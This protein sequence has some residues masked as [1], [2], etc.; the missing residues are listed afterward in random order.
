MNKILKFSL[1]NTI[2]I[3][4]LAILVIVGGIYSTNNIKVESFPNLVMPT[5]FVQATYG[6]H[7]TQELEDQL[8]N[9]IEDSIKQQK[10]YDT[11]TSTSRNNS[12][13][14]TVSYPFHTDIDKQKSTLEEAINKV[15]IPDGAKVEV[16]KLDNAAQPVYEVAFAGSGNQDIQSSLENDLVPKL[17]RV[18]GVGT[19]SLDGTKTKKISIVVNQDKANK[20]GLTL[21]N[22]QDAIQSKNYNV[23]FGQVNSDGTKISLVMVG[24][25]GSI[26]DLKNTEIAVGETNQQTSGTSNSYAGATNPQN[27]GASSFYIGSGNQQT[28][29]AKASVQQP[30]KVKL[31]DL[32]NIQTVYSQDEITRSNGKDSLLLSVTKTQDA[33]TTEVVNNIK[34]TIST[35]NKDHHYTI[36]TVTDQGKDVQD[37]ISSLLKE[38]GYGILFAILVILLFL[39]N[40]RATLIAIVSLPL[41][42]L[43]TITVLNQMDYTLNMMTLGG[44]AVAVG[45]I[46]DDSIVVIENIFRWRQ[47]NKQ[48]SMKEVA[49]HATKEVFG[50][51]TSSTLTTMVVFLPIAFVT[52]ILGE[53]FRP[54]ALAVVFSIL[55]SL[56]VAMILVPVLGSIFFKNVKHVEKPSRIV[57]L[58]EKIL[59]GAFR[60][61]ALVII[62]SLLLLVGSFAMIPKL[63]V[64]FLPSDDTNP[65]IQANITVPSFLSVDQMNSV[66][67]NVEAY[68]KNKKGIDYSQ[69]SVGIS[70]GSAMMFGGDNN[71]IQFYIH[72]KSGQNMNNLLDVYRN[73]IEKIAQSD[74]KDSAVTVSQAQSSWN[75]TGNNID[76]QLYGSDLSKLTDASNQVTKLLSKNNQL[77]NITSNV[78]SNQKQWKFE[79]NSAGDK[80]GVTYQQLM[81]AI[82]D[83]VS[84]TVV[85]NYDINGTTQEVDLSYDKQITSKADLENIEM[86]TSEGTKKVSDVATITEVNVPTTLYQDDGNQLVKISAV[87]KGNDTT[88]VTDEVKKDINTLSLPKGITVSYDG[89]AKMTSDGLSSLGLAMGAAVGLVFIV[90]TVTFSGILTPLV[91]LSSLLFVPIGALGGL[92][93]SGQPISMS[94][95]IGMLMLIG[96]VV[97]NAIV[98]LDRVEKNRK[99]GTELQ[100]AIVEA[101]K[102]RLRPILMTA[103]ATI[104]ALIPLATSTSSSGLISKGLA[105]AVIGGLTTSTLLTLIFVPVLYSL[106]GKFRN[107]LTDDDLK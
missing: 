64:A 101:A 40:I 63:G 18:S 86:K 77:K 67:K 4:L 20:Y 52:G 59:R 99:R 14:I 51:V 89:G 106:V 30:V 35:F 39:R 11:L 88:K 15:T 38:G 1:K 13:T 100:E 12:A 47:E 62:L 98:L 21:L 58:Y 8:T 80:A 87:I 6:G 46:I 37:S 22:I 76:I 16:Q 78:G 66:A 36:Y 56:I 50:A 49:L 93:I 32:A 60:K 102:I 27:G 26:K 23:A 43:A 48:I 94:A 96:V 3:I 68:L 71:V 53:I 17:E 54:F 9:P 83:Y 33:N 70:G 79:V 104:F 61:K 91:I 44:M 57:W 73:D 105:V 82:R 103:F 5:L 55:A 29:S 107:N 75:Q 25:S 69:V 28:G 84:T 65:S 24:N 7:S 81:S 92:L 19:V 74:Y 97:S 85:G 2:A 95:M 10:G 90:L 41:S 42:I 34:D 72:F 45:R 31:S